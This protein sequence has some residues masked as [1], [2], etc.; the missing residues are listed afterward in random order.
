MT[1]SKVRPAGDVWE[2]AF[3]EFMGGGYRHLP[4]DLAV[5]VLSAWR[6]EIEAAVR[7]EAEAAGYQRA[8]REIEAS[9][10]SLELIGSLHETGNVWCY[11]AEE[12]DA[13]LAE[14]SRARFGDGSDGDE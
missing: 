1:D 9:L 4:K 5:K 6:K 3:S 8:V 10:R 14:M 2:L 12:V 11:R 13:I 7:A